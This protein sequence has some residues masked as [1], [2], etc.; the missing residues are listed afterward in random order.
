MGDTT[1][2]H[3]KYHL[4]SA[5]NDYTYTWHFNQTTDELEKDGKIYNPPTDNFTF[6]GEELETWPSDAVY[7]DYF[8][9]GMPHIN[10]YAGSMTYTNLKLYVPKGT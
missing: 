5:D 8:F 6:Y 3:R 7:P 10:Y 2:S 9:A 1:Y 4:P